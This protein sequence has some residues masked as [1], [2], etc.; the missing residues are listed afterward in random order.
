MR[1]IK[2]R[3]WDKEIQEMYYMDD[4]TTR[5]NSIMDMV[6]VLEQLNPYALVGIYGENERREVTNIELMQYTGLKDKNG[7]EIYEG[8]IV[9]A[10]SGTLSNPDNLKRSVYEIVIDNKD[11]YGFGTRQ[12]GGNY[13]SSPI[14]RSVTKYYSVIGNI[15]EKPE[16]LEGAE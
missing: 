12:V 7:T 2:F 6:V 3:A 4:N 1:E 16:L 11:S 9:E 15:Y 8:D 13:I 14:R 5:N 10:I